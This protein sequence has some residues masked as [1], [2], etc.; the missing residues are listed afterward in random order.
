[1]IQKKVKLTRKEADSY[2]IPFGKFNMVAVVTDIGMIGCGM[3]DV[4]ALDNFDYPAAR[5]KSGTGG[6][7]ATI[8]DILKGIVKDANKAAQKRGIK[9]GMTGAQALDFL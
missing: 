5:I 9:I 6:P 7:I 2:V 8:D 4:F 1:M 3:F